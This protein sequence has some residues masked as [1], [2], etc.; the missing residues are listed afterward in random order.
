MRLAWLSATAQRFAPYLGLAVILVLALQW[1]T[2]FDDGWLV[3]AGLVA[4]FLLTLIIIAS[5]IRITDWDASRAAERGLAARDALTSALEFDD[6]DDDVHRL[7]QTRAELLVERSDPSRAIP[8]RADGSRLRQSGMTA[9]LALLIG[10]LPPLGSASALSADIEA[11]LDAEAA[12]IEKLAA[13]VAAADVETSDEIIAELERLA[14]ELRDAESLEQALQSLDDADTRLDARLDPAF[15]SQKAAIQGLARD[16]ALRPLADGAPLD[17]ASQFD[18]LADTLSS[19]STPELAALADRLSDLAESQAAGNPE[20]SGHLADA[21]RALE[22]GDLSEARISLEEAASRQRTGFDQLSGQ[23]ALVETSRALDGARTRLS[24]EG[25]GTSELAEGGQGED[26][27]GQPG[28]GQGQGS[29]QGQSGEGQAEGAGAGG[30]PQ[31]GASG[32]ITGVAPGDGSASGD[33]G[34]GRI[35]ADVG[36]D[37]GTDVET[38]EVFAPIDEGAL[39]DL[40]QVGIDGGAGEGDIV[41]RADGVTQRGESI[42]PYAQVLPEYLNEAADALSELRLPPSMRSIVQAY[43]DLLAAEAR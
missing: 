34:Q 24:G 12:Q 41:G 36:Q 29:G 16:L 27:Q 33:G 22:E 17:A 40:V 9:A 35:G 20:L 19:L 42:V 31:D 21:S 5:A 18:H 6:P 30:Q 1:S 25:A 43:F 11:A 2:P 3:A 32:E 4:T 10:L 26:G 28:E 38:A 37:H 14:Q 15:L 8:F 13:A 23:Q 7:I 39:A